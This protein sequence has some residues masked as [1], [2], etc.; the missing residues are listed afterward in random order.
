SV[1][2]CGLDEA[3]LREMVA[4]VK[5]ELDGQEDSCRIYAVCRGC[6]ERVQVLGSGER[7]EERVAVV[8]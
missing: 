1:F 6:A 3:G 4:R 2:E 5:K 8:V 7:Y